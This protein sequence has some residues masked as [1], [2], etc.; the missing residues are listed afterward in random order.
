[1]ITFSSCNHSQIVESWAEV[2]VIALANCLRLESMLQV[3]TFLLELKQ[4]LGLVV[5]DYL[6][7]VLRSL[8]LSL[9]R[10]VLIKLLHASDPRGYA[11]PHLQI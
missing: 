9:V 7:P 10:L 5:V 11:S 6:G 4:Y 2:V 8:L 3:V 1:M